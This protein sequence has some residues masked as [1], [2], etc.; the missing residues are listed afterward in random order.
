MARPA[1]GVYNKAEQN[2]RKVDME[3]ENMLDQKSKEFFVEKVNELIAAPSCC[4]EAR[5]A[6]KAWLEAVGTEKEAEL[7]E[8]L[9]KELELDITPIDGL[10]G[11][12][13]SEA[14][15]EVFGEEQAKAML[16]HAEE[17]KAAGAEYCDCPACTACAA[18]LGHKELLL[19]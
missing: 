5:E 14:G 12:V 6:G 7:S 10:I 9:V 3:E 19:Q 17:I 16:A 11:F 1:G 15:A 8:A 18:I 2:L 4:A 13:G